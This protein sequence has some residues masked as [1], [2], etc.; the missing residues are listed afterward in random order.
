M[1]KT[2]VDIKIVYDRFPEFAGKLRQRAGQVVRKTAFD[3]QRDYQQSTRV[4]T[5]A[6]K[7]S[8]YVV[9]ANSSTYAAAEAAAHQMNPE[10]EILPEVAHPDAFGAIVAVG[11]SYAAI[12]EFGG[13]TGPDGTQA[14]VGDGALTQAANNNRQPFLDA[15][16]TLLKFQGD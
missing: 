4:D 6:Q 16:N 7:N 10:A 15:L 1:A 11:V 13:A 2:T 14:R 3:V 5:G 12:N 8:A 9:T